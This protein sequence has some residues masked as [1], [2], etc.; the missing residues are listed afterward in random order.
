LN[1][2]DDDGDQLVD[3]ADD[4]CAAGFSCADPIPAGWEALGYLALA[5][6]LPG[7]ERACPATFPNTAYLGNDGLVTPPAQCAPCSCGAATNE[8]CQLPDLETVDP[9]FPGVSVV[10][11]SNKACGLNPTFVG[12]QDVNANWSGACAGA[13][14]YQGGQFCSGSACNT[15]VSSGP[16]LVAGGSCAPAGGD[17]DVD[18]A[19]W[20]FA[21]KACGGAAE[22]AGCAGG[23]SCVAKPGVGFEADVCI[24]RAGDYACPAPFLA[25]SVYYDPAQTADDRG[26]TDCSCGAPSG[27]TCSVTVQVF[28]DYQ[29]GQCNN[30]IGVFTS[31][32]T[33]GGCVNLANNPI[34]GNVKM[35]VGS[36]TPGS[37]SVAPSGGQPQGAATEG[38]ATTF[39]C[40]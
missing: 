2:I 6:S 40:L 31:D 21:G 34:V 16:T 37:C 1:G 14:G 25:R 10:R 30:Q 17:A 23:G 13:F 11:I 3:C 38:G 18:P 8:Q 22:G 36:Q 39:C 5:R 28:K 7:E 15:S 33:T 26:C 20:G 27:G 19:T 9:Q 29:V 35:V 24:A 12:Y 4:D 32:D